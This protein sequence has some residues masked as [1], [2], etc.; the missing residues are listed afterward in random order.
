MSRV[1]EPASLLDV[2]KDTLRLYDF[3]AKN[4]HKNTQIA[5]L[6]VPLDVSPDP[7]REASQNGERLHRIIDIATY[8]PTKQP[9]VDTAPP[10]SPVPAPRIISYHVP[11]VCYVHRRCGSSRAMFVHVHPRGTQ[12]GRG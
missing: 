11:Q 8:H 7:N 12:S 4:H 10:N 2:Q 9:T 1:R 3:P 6:R 5:A